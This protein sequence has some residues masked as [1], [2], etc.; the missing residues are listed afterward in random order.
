MFITS[1]TVRTHL[2][3]ARISLHSVVSVLLVL[4]VGE[5]DLLADVVLVH[6]SLRKELRAQHTIGVAVHDQQSTF[7]AVLAALKSTLYANTV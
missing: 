6:A 1:L 7:H 3:K 5:S 4:W 2:T